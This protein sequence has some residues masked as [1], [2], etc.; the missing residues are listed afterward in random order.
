MGPVRGGGRGSQRISKSGEQ[1]ILS[2]CFKILPPRLFDNRWESRRNNRTVPFFFLLPSGSGS[3]CPCP[4][5]VHTHLPDSG[6]ELRVLGGVGL[7]TSKQVAEEVKKACWVE[8]GG[9]EAVQ[10]TLQAQ[11]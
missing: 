9:G 11:M 7:L 10:G 4:S 3:G 1:D 6:T 8:C 5:S 2:F